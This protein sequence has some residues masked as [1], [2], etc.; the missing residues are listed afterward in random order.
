MNKVVLFPLLLHLGSATDE[1][2]LECQNGTHCI[3]GEVDTAGLPF[4]PVTEEILLHP[5]LHE[6]GWKCDCPLGLAGLRCDRKFIS[7]DKGSSQG[8]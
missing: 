1:C 2:P 3:V 5:N 8:C 6:D 7:C 4:D